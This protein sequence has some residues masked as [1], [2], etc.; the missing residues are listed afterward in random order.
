MA[1]ALEE[2]VERSG[3]AIHLVGHSFGGLGALR[4]HVPLFSLTIL[5]APAP[6]ALLGPADAGHLAAFRTMTDAYADA[7]RAGDRE[8]IGSMIEFYGGAGSW[9]AMPITVRDYA[10]ATTAVNLIDWESAY[11]FTLD[12]ALATFSD[13]PV[14]VLVGARS[15]P[16]V[17]RANKLIAE[18]NPGATSKALAGAAHF[19]IAT[20][21]AAVV[22]IIVRQVA[23]TPAL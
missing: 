17:I 21:P 7:Y 6:G 16:A 14:C 9:A 20:H 18:R 11:G 5:E 3:S 1:T 12:A 19:M 8:A 22:D 13:L 10:A 2:V 15:H 23:T 4:R